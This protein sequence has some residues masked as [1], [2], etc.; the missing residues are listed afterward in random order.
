MG[1]GD[2]FLKPLASLGG[3]VQGRSAGIS[4]TV[5]APRGPR[6]GLG[7]VVK[8]QGGGTA[9]PQDR[10]SSAQSYI[11]TLWPRHSGFVAAPASLGKAPPC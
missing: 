7:N 3:G 5:C 9:Q 10:V 11:S 8:G 6:R 2:A 4:C 1:L